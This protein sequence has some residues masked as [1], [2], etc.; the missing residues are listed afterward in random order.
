MPSNSKIIVL[1]N[2]GSPKEARRI[3][4]ALVERR[5]AACVNTVTT[6][7]ESVYRWKEKIE[8]AKEYLLLIKTSRA[9]FA[10]VERTIHDLH[11][12]EVPEIIA[13]PIVSGSRDYLSWLGENTR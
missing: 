7:V 1:T 9:C 10:A 2:C 4:K 3:A 11:S 13:L 6:P 8:R 5:L 12:Y